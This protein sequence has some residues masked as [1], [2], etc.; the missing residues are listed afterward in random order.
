VFGALGCIAHFH[1][2]IPPLVY[3]LLVCGVSVSFGAYLVL[4][5]TI[6]GASFGK[7]NFGKHFGFLQLASSAASIAMPQLASAIADA[8]DSFAWMHVL[9]ALCLLLSTL[10]LAVVPETRDFHV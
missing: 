2:P 7:L 8:T 9:C 4:F 5:P 3:L 1:V 6:C 10:L